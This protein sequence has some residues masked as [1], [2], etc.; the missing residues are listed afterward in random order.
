[1]TLRRRRPG[2][3][4]PVPAGATATST[5][6]RR[7]ACRRPATGRSRRRPTPAVAADAAAATD[8]AVTE[9]L[10]LED[11]EVHFPIRGGLLDA[12]RGRPRGVVRA[13]DGIDLT[14]RQRRGPRPRRRV[15]QR[16]DDDRPGHRQA[17]P[18]DRAARSPFDGAGR[19]RPVG[20]RRR[21]ASYRRRVQLDLPGPVRDAEPEA[22]DPRLRGRAARSSTGIGE[23]RAERE[24]QGHRGARGGRPAARP[25]TSRSATRTSCRAASASASSSPARWS[26][27][28]ELDRRRRAG[29]DARRLDPD[30]AAAAD[31]R[32]AQGARADLPVHHP[33]PVARLGDRRPDRGDVP[34]QDHG[35]RAGRARSSARPHNPYTAGARLG[36]RR[37]P[38]RR[39]RATR[40]QRTI[41]VGETPDAAHIPTG[42]RFHP[43]CP[44]AFDRC[45]VEEPPLFDVGDGQP[46]A[47]WLAEPG[48]VDLPILEPSP[49]AGRRSRPNRRS[50]REP[51]SSSGLV[52]RRRRWRGRSPSRRRR[53]RSGRRCRSRASLRSRRAGPS[54]SSEPGSPRRRV[55][56]RRSRSGSRPASAGSPAARARRALRRGQDHQRGS[57]RSGRSR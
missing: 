12:L 16:Q 49:A 13:V 50:R 24:A 6:P 39:R 38:T 36:R 52:S 35:D 42:C 14:I 34:R 3:L 28:P 25:P 48:R 11:L 23:S 8:R 7:A 40:A 51:T 47:C 15:G 54:R 5:G 29:L 10:R 31:A 2:R 37:H 33:R 43:R 20:R 9:L 22:D 53:R 19:Q 21:C 17:H 41:L 26:M 55:S 32:P 44:L 57:P 18:P 30:R 1:M 45:P 46:A 4:P 56:G 27:D